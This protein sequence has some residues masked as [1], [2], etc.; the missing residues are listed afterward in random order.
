MSPKKKY[1]LRLIEL[2]KNDSQIGALYPVKSIR[3]KALEEGLSLAQIIDVFLD[4]YGERPALGERSYEVVRE[5]KTDKKV[6]Q[7][8]PD[9]T[10]ISYGA[11][12]QRVKALSMAWRTHAH[13]TV[14]RG[15][16]VMI[17][18]FADVDF[19]TL[20][21]ACAYAEAVTVPIQSST[22]GADL[23]EIVANIEPVVIAA[24]LTDLFVAVE[25]AAKHPTV[26]SVIVFNYNEHVDVEKKIV[27]QAKQIL[28]DA[29]GNKQLFTLSE[30]IAFGQNQPWTWLPTNENHLENCA[31]ILHSSGSTGKPKGAIISA[32]AFARNWIGLASTLPILSVGGTGYFTLQPDLT[33]LLED[34]R[35][36][37]P[38]FLSTFLSLFPRI[39]ELIYQHFQNEVSKRTQQGNGN[40][41]AVE[42]GVKKEMRST[43]LADRLGC[44]VFGSAPTAPKVQEFMTLSERRV[45]C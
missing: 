27:T 37:R 30:L 16:F 32:K 35:L 8:L 14:K 19:A 20:D 23:A 43:Y 44:I 3:E 42:E 25:L 28:A 36:A 10:T 17:M 45:M 18:G 33:T 7:Y 11:L 4:G 1:A 15:E 31:G 38:T 41:V 9:F 13:C 29:D 34:I 12:N 22:S 39:F 6:R 40:R 5:E 24:T 2:G 21:M 26:K